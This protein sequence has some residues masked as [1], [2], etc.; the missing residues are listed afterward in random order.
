MKVVILAGGLGTRLSEETIIKPKPMVEI[1]GKPML[2][3]IMNIYAAYAFKEFVVA[4][5]YKGEM[6][7]EYFI[8][9]HYLSRNLSVRLDTGNVTIHDG[10]NEDW[11]IHLL[12]TGL[13]TQTG[14]RI[15]RAIE[16][17]GHEP[18]MLTYGDGVSNINITKLL[19]FHRSHGK[20]A[21]ITA[22]R[23]T[24]RFGQMV[25]DGEK[26]IQFEEKPQIG[27]GWINGG[28]FVLQP[29]VIEYIQGDQTIWEREPLERLA[30]EGQLIAYRH[31]DFW[32]CMDTLR[33]TQ[34]LEKYWA[35]GNAPWKIWA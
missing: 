31:D 11:L 16:F 24:A 29:E 10:S 23:P 17:I 7:K 33:D 6:I 1:G 2:W 35:E 3:H 22:V 13:A 5:G 20:L 28:F 9:Y 14:G 32:H 30:S 19:A 27:E 4:L 8:N 15:K 21:T 25:I 26:V 18:L 12:D 34:L